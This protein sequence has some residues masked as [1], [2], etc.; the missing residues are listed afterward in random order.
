[1]PAQPAPIT[2]TS[3]EAATTRDAT[4]SSAFRARGNYA[5]VSLREFLEILA[6]HG[7]EL[8]RLPVVGGGIAPGRARVEERL[9]DAGHC[10]RHLEAEGRVDPVGDVFEPAGERSV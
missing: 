8:V 6:E 4:A 3:W 5:F 1:M 7:R 10:H 9:V 2:R